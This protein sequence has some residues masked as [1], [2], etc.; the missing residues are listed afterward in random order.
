MIGIPTFIA[1]VP[2]GIDSPADLVRNPAAILQVPF[3]S[4]S[5]MP[6]IIF[7][8]VTLPQRD[9]QHVAAAGIMVLVIVLLTF[10]TVAILIRQRFQKRIRW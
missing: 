10:N 5:A 8:W 9:F 3:D 2:G 7:N 4:G 1:S 6:L